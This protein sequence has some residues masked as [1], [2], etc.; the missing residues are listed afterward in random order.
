M[1]TFTLEQI[2]EATEDFSPVNKIGEGGFGPVY[3]VLHLKG[4][5]N[6]LL[7]RIKILWSFLAFKIQI[8]YWIAGSII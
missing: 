5:P 3:K 1:G 4:T 2:R 6:F 7:L 8:N